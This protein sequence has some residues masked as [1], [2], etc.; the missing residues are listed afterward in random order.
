MN[1]F[2]NI[3]IMIGGFIEFFG[4]LGGISFLVYFA[5]KCYRSRPLNED[6]KVLRCESCQCYD[7]CAAVMHDCLPDYACA[8]W[9][10]K[11]P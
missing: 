2:V 10:E 5:L 1:T 8:Y 9:K 7:T 11:K 6:E 3:C 4:L